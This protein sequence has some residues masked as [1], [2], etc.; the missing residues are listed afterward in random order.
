MLISGG[1]F[2]SKTLGQTVQKGRV[3]VP[4]ACKDF[5]S[6]VTPAKSPDADK[7]GPWS[8]KVDE[9]SYGI[10]SKEEG[11]KGRYVDVKGEIKGLLVNPAIGVSTSAE[12]YTG[13]LTIQG[14]A[15]LKN[16]HLTEPSRFNVTGGV[17]LGYVFIGLKDL[18]SSPGGEDGATIP[19][20]KNVRMEL[21]KLIRRA[22]KAG[23]L[24]KLD[25]LVEHAL[26]DGRCDG[27]GGRRG[28]G[29]AQVRYRE[30]HAA[31]ECARPVQRGGDAVPVYRSAARLF[32]EF[33]GGRR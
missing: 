6:R 26:C 27:E 21:C 23:V 9:H 19:S 4:V 7:I 8:A 31:R 12:N 16:F 13:K 11:A 30:K 1:R 22:E 28:A 29:H 24:E 15:G 5:K 14:E 33:V 18:L 2:S 32:D 17:G 10:V 25:E 20:L 3:D